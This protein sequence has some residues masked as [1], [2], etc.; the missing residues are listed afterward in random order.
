MKYFNDYDIALALQRHA[1]HP[2]LSRAAQFLKEFKD[3]VD[4]HSDG[5]AYWHPPVLAANKLMTLLE[6]FTST[7][8]DTDL[9]VEAQFRAALSPI[10]SFYT[11]RGNAAGM[12]YPEVG[13]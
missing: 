3:E 6:G 5:W 2:V 8:E 9:M 10:K 12:K 4:A 7:D 11:R 1:N 13:A